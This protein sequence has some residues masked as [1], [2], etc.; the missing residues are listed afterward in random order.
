MVEITVV[1]V[2]E[3]QFR[4]LFNALKK[5]KKLHLF[6]LEYGIRIE[7][8]VLVLVFEFVSIT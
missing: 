4:H 6:I 5:K 3:D 1:L 7:V 8:L 2:Y